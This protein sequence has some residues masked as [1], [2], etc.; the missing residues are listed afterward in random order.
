MTDTALPGRPT[1]RV[2]LTLRR[3]LSLV[4]ALLLYIL[5]IDAAVETYQAGSDLRLWVAL[6]VAAYVSFTLWLIRQQHSSRPGAVASI[7][8][9][10]FLFLVLLA[11]TASMPN[12]LQQGMRV[13]TLSTSTVLSVTTAGVLALA[14]VSLTIG[15]PLPIAGRAVAALAACYGVVAFGTGIAWH[16]SYVQLLQGG[17][18]WE[19]LP[20]FLQGAF[21][22]ALVVLPLA[23]AL[24]VGV[25]LAHVKVRGRRHRIVAFALAIAMAYAAFTA[26]P[27]PPAG[28]PT[29]ASR[30][31]PL[32]P[33]K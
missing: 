32:P 12:G 23:F 16:R 18:P 21:V 29:P 28:G 2:R 33:P 5:L 19:R 26:T 6:P 24:E 31:G 11:V 8:L 20:Y 7:W 3:A 13:A 30:P 10:A 1:D 4:T 27:T 25:A 9:S 22:G 14:L 15:S 17:S